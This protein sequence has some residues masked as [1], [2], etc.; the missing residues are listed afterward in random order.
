MNNIEKIQ[1][2]SYHNRKMF[3]SYKFKKGLGNCMDNNKMISQYMQFNKLLLSTLNVNKKSVDVFDGYGIKNF[4]YR[5]FFEYLAS[6]F[7]L[8]PDFIDKATIA[9]E[10]FNPE[11]EMIEIE[12][13]YKTKNGEPANF[14][15]NFI[16]QSQTEFLLS[17][18]K[19]DTKNEAYIDQMTKAKPKSYIDNMAMTNKLTKTP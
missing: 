7:N 12:S 17:I 4:S 11:N 13:E 6:F 2:K 1:K 15:Y 9:L 8:I 18:R 3:D 14:V 16:K 10:F 19:L 5:G